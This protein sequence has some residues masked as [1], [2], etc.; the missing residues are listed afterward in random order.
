MNTVSTAAAVAIRSPPGRPM[1][2]GSDFL[3]S[4]AS[5]FR[6][7]SRACGST[8]GP[9]S[10]NFRPDLSDCGRLPRFSSIWRWR[11]G[12]R[13]AEGIAGELEWPPLRTTAEVLPGWLG[14]G[15][16]NH[17]LVQAHAA[18][19]AGQEL[20]RPGGC[21]RQ[22]PDRRRAR[23]AYL[24]REGTRTDGRGRGPVRSRHC[25]NWER[26]VSAARCPPH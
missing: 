18:R 8:R 11:L 7:S 22:H 15:P 16:P 9:L 4:G 17:G 10:K 26:S 21:L 3:N 23:A 25:F 2:L 12:A 14:G 5:E 24:L 13:Q 19:R 1:G 20:R 6:G